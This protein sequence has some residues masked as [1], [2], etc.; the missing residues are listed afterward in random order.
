MP[1][2][3][4]PNLLIIGAQKS[5]STF[6]QINIGDHPEV[7]MLPGEVPY[8]EDPDY[9]G[10]PVAF[11]AQRFR[12]RPET[13]RALKRP[14]YIGRPEVPRRLAADLPDARLIA[15]LRNPLDRAIAAYFHQ[16]KYG[17]A[18]LM[19]LARGMRILLRQ[20]RIAGHARTAEILEFGLYFKHLSGYRHFLDKG[21]LR[22]FLHE[23][24][25]RDPLGAARESYVFLGIDPAFRPRALQGRPMAAVYNGARLRTHVLRGKVM[26]RYTA[27]RTRLHKRRLGP[28]RLALAGALTV[29]DRH[30]LARILPND[31]PALPADLRRDLIGYYRDDILALQDMLGRDL[32][33]WLR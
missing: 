3:P 6:L 15:V 1:E 22:I 27:D 18:P 4:L 33:D 11:F 20:G 8:F 12:G 2:S 24:I 9:D 26:Y 31:R 19:P 7:F 13:I 23:D 5:A 14:N 30:V 32:S 29:L 21:R 17:T 28:A 25:T 10:D 16:V